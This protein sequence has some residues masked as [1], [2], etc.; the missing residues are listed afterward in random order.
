[1]NVYEAKQ[2]ARRE[3]LE[4]AAERAQERASAAFKRADL[5]E[6]VSGIPLGQPVL[7]GH[8][9]EGRHRAAIKR[10]DN[11]MRKGIDESKRAAELA[12]RA[13]S[14]GTGGISSDDPDAIEKLKGELA[15]CEKRQSDMKEHNAKWK[16]KGNKV[17]RQA[18]GTWVDPPYPAFCLTNNSAN[19]RRIKLRIAHLEKAATREHKE[20]DRP[21]G[22]KL[23]Q[24]VE[25]NRLQIIFPGKPDEATRAKLKSY[26]FRWSPLT[27]AWQRHLSN[28]AIWAADQ[29]LKQQK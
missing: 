22:V 6:E 10:A 23:V 7:V 5:R 11:A 19:A 21:N 8:H 3:R 15:T 26:G 14:V 9:S 24:N 2:E 28:A 18:D 12:G 20:V 27:G 4:A 29:C 16:A 1:M 17:G 25:E 13:S